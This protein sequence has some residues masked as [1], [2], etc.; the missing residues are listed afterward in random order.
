MKILRAKQVKEVD[1]YTIKNEPILS[2][3]LMERAA[4]KCTE[5]Y[6]KYYD[7]R[8][9]IA[10]FTGTGNNGGDGLVMARLLNNKGYEVSVYVIEFTKKYSND[11][12]TNLNRLENYPDIDIT[13]LR[14]SS[15]F[16]KLAK[17]TIVIDAIFG[18]GLSRPVEGFTAE[19][20]Q[21]INA[22]NLDVVAID[23]PSGLQA[24][25]NPDTFTAVKAKYTFTFEF[26]F[27]S[28]F[29]PENE[30]YVGE[31]KTINIGLSKEFMEQSKTN[32]HATQTHNVKPLIKKRS[33]FAHKGTCG[34]GVIFAGSYGMAGASI[35]SAKSAYRSGAG[36]ITV[37][38]PKCNYQILQISVPEAVLHIDQQEHHLSDIPDM[39][40]FKAIAIG[41]GI[42]FH[43]DTV[44]ILEHLIIN[45]KQELIIDADALTILAQRPDLLDAVP[46][47]S[48]L[49]PHIKEFERIV[50]KQKNHYLRLQKQKELAEKLNSIII[51]KGAY[52]SIY[53][54]DGNCFFNTTGNPGM[55]T[56]GSGDVLTGMLLGLKAQG[57]SSKDASIIAVFLHGKAGD[58]ASEQKNSFNIIASDLIDNINFS[59]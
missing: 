6:T 56:A 59:M 42:G 19:I 29:M 41:P 3:N 24:E 52:T 2:I 51:L 31:F 5:L 16:P 25:E 48:I 22:S 47:G 21:K 27:L 55:A 54:P 17:N 35:L 11:F 40:K 4:E 32:Y 18:S 30:Q 43:K 13:Y 45:N 8:K 46:P 50:G 26:P 57:Y 9:S 14:D 23:A 28:F 36:L 58:I 10:I 49:T 38:V 15:S 39:Q 37:A 1:L 12:K 20:I 44:K 33:K 53:T 34:H 7:F